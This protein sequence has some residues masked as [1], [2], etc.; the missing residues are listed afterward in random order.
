LKNFIIVFLTCL[1]NFYVTAQELPKTSGTNWTDV[2]LKAMQKMGE[3]IKALNIETV[4]DF[5]FSK[6]KEISNRHGVA[7]FEVQ[8]L[9]PEMMCQLE[10][11]VQKE[12][13]IYYEAWY[14]EKKS[15]D[16]SLDAILKMKGSKKDYTDTYVELENTNDPSIIFKL[17]LYINLKKSATYI[18]YATKDGIDLSELQIGTKLN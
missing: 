14:L 13:T 1:F 15:T 17:V 2:D 5:Y 4:T 11:F 6:G 12:N 16:Y 8:P 3:T 7:K 10:H 9:N 18:K